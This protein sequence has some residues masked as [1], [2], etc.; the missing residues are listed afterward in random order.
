MEEFS[1]DRNQTR[2]LCKDC[3]EEP[4][5]FHQQPV[6]LVINPS[7]F[8]LKT[9]KD[10]LGIDKL[11][12]ILTNQWMNGHVFHI[13]INHMYMLFSKCIWFIMLS[14][15]NRYSQFQDEYSLEQIMNSP[16]IH[17]PLTKLQCWYVPVMFCQ[18][19]F[20][21]VHCGLSIQC[22]LCLNFWIIEFVV[23]MYW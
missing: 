4:Q 1:C 6:R 12:P 5:T 14:F 15:S 8:V 10:S 3:L 17:D 22:W 20:V 7:N 19:C 16:K 18:W 23:Y 2:T 11:K 13:K 9:S 21:N